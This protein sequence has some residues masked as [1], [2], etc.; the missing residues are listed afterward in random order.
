MDVNLAETPAKKVKIF[1]ETLDPL[2]VL[3]S[4]IFEL[5]F[6]H[7]GNDDVLEAS[8]VSPL[9]FEETETSAKCVEKLHLRVVIPYSEEKNEKY[10]NISN[11]L[12][13]QRNY[14]NIYLH[15]FHNIIPEILK[16]LEGRSWKK[17]YISVRNLHTKKDFQDVMKLIEPSV[18]NLSI[19][20]TSIRNHE[21]K[22]PKLILSFP[23][24]NNLDLSRSN[25]LLMEEISENCKNIKTLKIDLDHL[26][27]MKHQQFAQQILSNN[28]KLEELTIWR[29]S[30]EF[31]FQLESIK[32]YKFKLKTF[33]FKNHD[34]PSDIEE[35]C[36]FDFLESQA[37]SLESLRL[38]EWMG[39]EVFKM[40]FK[41][42]KLRELTIDLYDVESTLDWNSMQLHQSSS[43]TKFHMDNY[44]KNRQKIKIFNAIFGAMPNLKFLTMD[45]LDNEVRFLS[46]I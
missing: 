14:Q 32:T 10:L 13:S 39:V 24:L 46:N 19:S 2:Q 4:D 11:D 38:E 41:M 34:Q 12:I 18:E 22:A 3:H 45:K 25:G 1:S 8:T 31:L 44:R 36:L 9:W 28:D 7:F 16:I 40:Q 23:K 21:E 42:P 20:L 5:I 43:I 33:L 29:C 6:Q 30:A 37:N 17:V 35:N 15:N 26:T 27:W